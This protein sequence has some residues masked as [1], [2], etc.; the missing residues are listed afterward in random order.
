[1]LLMYYAF[2]KTNATLLITIN[3]FGC[4]IE[5]VYIALY[6]YYSPK[7]APTVK[8]LGLTIGG[9]GLIVVLTHFLLAASLQVR[10][11][12]W[13]CLLFSVSVFAAPLC[14]VKQV[15]R[16]KS[17]E[18]MPFSLSFSLTLNAVM[19][20]FYG[21]LIKDFN[22]A[23]PNIVG[24]GFGI[25]QMVVYVRYKDARKV[26]DEEKPKLPELE[27]ENQTKVMEE[28][29]PTHLAEQMIQV[30]KLTALSSPPEKVPV[31][32]PPPVV[33]DGLAGD[34]HVPRPSMEIPVAV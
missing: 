28:K 10:I 7:K 23:I 6:L 2:L 3:S 17:V 18:F 13:I 33:W 16:T 4:F 15:I 26:V 34:L 24:F 29:L 21:F 25:I 11:V 1:M 20:F 5:T 19:W 22:I 31:V 8:L 30:A 32:P 14:I 9:F 27:K 12:G